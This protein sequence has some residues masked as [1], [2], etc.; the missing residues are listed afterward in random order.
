MLSLRQTFLVMF[1]TLGQGMH[2]DTAVER[3]ENR[4]PSVNEK[5]V[6]MRVNAYTLTISIH[7]DV[8]RTGALLYSLIF[9]C[10]YGVS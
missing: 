10:P 5:T 2:N 6:Y 4:K 3:E 8:E 1:W 9:T 7:T